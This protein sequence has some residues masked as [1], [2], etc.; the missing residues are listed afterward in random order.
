MI[1]QM[2]G[3]GRSWRCSRAALLVM[4]ESSRRAYPHEGCGW[5]LGPSPG[6][7]QAAIAVRNEEALTAAPS[8][9]LMGPDSYRAASRAAH[10]HG[11]DVLGVFH[12]HPDHPADP[13]ATDLAEAWPSW[14][15]VIVPVQAGVPGEP[16]G[17]LLR[18]DRSGFEAVRLESST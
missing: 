11:L 9:Y 7:V 5:L 3:A 1:L 13:S 18:D 16:H 17:W 2:G 14:L 12:S 4:E 15:Y 10:S 8:R 6:T